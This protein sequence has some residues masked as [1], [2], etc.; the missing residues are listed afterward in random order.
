MVFDRNLSSPILG[1]S[2]IS[3]SGQSNH[4]LPVQQLLLQPSAHEGCFA[5]QY[6]GPAELHEPSQPSHAVPLPQ[7]LHRNEQQGANVL[8]AN[9]GMAR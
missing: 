5:S 6:E 8:L 1:E 2:C 4:S 3:E 7:G 9:A